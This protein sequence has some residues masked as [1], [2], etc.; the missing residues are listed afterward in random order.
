MHWFLSGFSEILL[1]NVSDDHLLVLFR[2]DMQLRLFFITIIS[3]LLKIL[4]LYYKNLI[5]V[6]WNFKKVN[7]IFENNI[8]ITF[9]MS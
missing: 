3:S 1:K 6:L 2:A 9:K 8:Y 7:V 4:N 5:Y